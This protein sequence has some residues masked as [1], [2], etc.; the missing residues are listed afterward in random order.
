M[1]TEWRRADRQRLPQGAR[2]Y[3]GQLIIENVGYDAAGSYECLAYDSRRQPVTLLL[4]QLVVVSGP[5]KIV[6]SPPMP[7][8]VRSGEDVLIY[9]N[10]TGEGPIRVH[11]HGEGGTR[12]SS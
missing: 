5:P 9:C 10:A 7:I 3:G 12:L 8:A 6:F 1:R 11:W 4:A 2:I